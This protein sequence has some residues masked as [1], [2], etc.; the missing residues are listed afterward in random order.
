[1]QMR[2]DVRKWWRHCS[3]CEREKDIQFRDD[4]IEEE[5]RLEVSGTNLYDSGNNWFLLI[6]EKLFGS[7]K[8]F[9]K[10]PEICISKSEKSRS[11]VED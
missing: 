8:F 9:T 10:I 2:S 4:L 7:W 1:M 5:E 3:C 6:I 11:D